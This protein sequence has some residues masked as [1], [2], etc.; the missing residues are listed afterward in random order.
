MSGNDEFE[1]EKVS[2]K[3]DQSESESSETETNNTGGL[4]KD[5]SKKIVRAESNV[6]NRSKVLLLGV[7]VVAAAVLGLFTFLI[8]DA[9][10]EDD[11]R[12]AVSSK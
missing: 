11:F 3:D 12:A 2:S 8:V 5:S 4:S 10:E 7:M 1:H 9:E 6:V